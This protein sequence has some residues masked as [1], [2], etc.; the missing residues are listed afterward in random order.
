MFK[1]IFLFYRAFHEIEPTFVSVDF[2]ENDS[3][4]MVVT[5]RPTIFPVETCEMVTDGVSENVK[6]LNDILPLEKYGLIDSTPEQ[7]GLYSTPLMLTVAP[8]ISTFPISFRS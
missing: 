6:P 2:Q 5:A 8:E 3:V 1:K 7:T 4:V